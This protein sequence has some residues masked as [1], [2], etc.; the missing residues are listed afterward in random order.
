[1]R[2]KHRLIGGYILLI[3]MSVLLIAIFSQNMTDDYYDLV[4]YPIVF[5]VAFI[6]GDLIYIRSMRKEMKRLKA[7][8]EKQ[9]R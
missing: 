7:E 6:A 2:V 5:L 3:I 8:K 4:K 1:M 9:K